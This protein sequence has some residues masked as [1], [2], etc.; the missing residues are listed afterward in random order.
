VQSVCFN[1]AEL[2]DGNATSGF[3][4]QSR[5]S[6]WYES[7]LHWSLENA[8]T[9]D[10]QANYSR[11]L[12]HQAARDQDPESYAPR[13]V[14][15]YGGLDCTERDPEDDE[16]LLDWYGISCGT[17]PSAGHAAGEGI[18]DELPYR[19]ASFAVLPQ[20]EDADG[21]CLVYAQLGAGVGR[22]Q[23]MKAA[24]SVLVG[25]VVAGWLVL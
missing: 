12:Y 8:E 15:L 14:N 7:G 25:A 18:C 3:V 9:F 22:F 20:D 5:P 19:V 23:P 2:F 13:R 21:T 17:G 6:E 4:N 16:G 10:A 1:L 11:I 24:A